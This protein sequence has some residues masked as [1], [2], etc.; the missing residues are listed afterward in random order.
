MIDA[1]NLTKKFGERRAVQKLNL[2]AKKGDVIGL[3]GP[4]GA[5]KTT[6]MRMMAGF[7]APSE[8]TVALCGRDI[9]TDTR[10][11]QKYLGY[12]PEGNPV[13]REMTPLSFLQ[14]IAR[15]RN[16]P[17]PQAKSAIAQTIH[18]TGL[19]KV[20]RQ[21]IDTLSKGYRR[22]AGLAQA[23][24]HD[25]P[26]LILDE[27]TDG[28]DPNQKRKMRDLLRQ[29]ASEKTIIISTHILEEARENCSRILVM[30]EGETLADGSPEALL[31]RSDYHQAISLRIPAKDAD[32]A[33]DILSALKG[34]DRYE[35]GKR[36]EALILTLFPNKDAE[37]L[38]IAQSAKDALTREDILIQTLRIEEGRLEDLFHQLTREKNNK[39]KENDNP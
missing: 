24:I 29:I 6:T 16:I 15:A 2:R 33:A 13:Y 23:L 38:Q 25:P 32:R 28:L 22:R 27:P 4:N 37:P 8:G 30:G 11:A 10:E 19:D 7:L 21:K 18:Q 5:G 34:I 14:F 9:A 12:L 17:P 3:L 36:G 26:I 31:A 35:T 1:V 39:N 20:A